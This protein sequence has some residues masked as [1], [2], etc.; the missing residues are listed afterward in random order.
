MVTAAAGPSEQK[1]SA[2]SAG[3]EAATVPEGGT[4]AAA[5]GKKEAAVKLEGPAEVK[6]LMLW[7]EDP[8]SEGAAGESIFVVPDLFLM[9]LAL[10]RTSCKSGLR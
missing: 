9:I 6:K 2:H 8:A 7:K 10:S 3:P 5:A 1:S 4:G